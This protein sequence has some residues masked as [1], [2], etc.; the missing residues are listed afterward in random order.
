M[1]QKALACTNSRK[2]GAWSATGASV[3]VA[4]AI[5]AAHK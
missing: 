1:A 3:A 4:I 2:A 5:S